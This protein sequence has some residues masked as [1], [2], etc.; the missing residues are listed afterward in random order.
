MKK[1]LKKQ[2]KA[3]A[4]K[5]LKLFKKYHTYLTFTIVLLTYIR[6]EQLISMLDVYLTTIA[7]A[8]IMMNLQ[9]ASMIGELY[10]K[11]SELLEIFK[12]VGGA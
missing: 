4:K 6:I 12:P 2:L 7:S 3:K 9:F 10:G 11:V 5:A 1:K 8:M